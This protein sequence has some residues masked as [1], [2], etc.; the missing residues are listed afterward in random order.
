MDHISF[1]LLQVKK[2]EG[3]LHLVAQ[4]T[5]TVDYDVAALVKLIFQ[6]CCDYQTVRG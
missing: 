2:M 3:E 6:Q 5:C 1:S 4:K